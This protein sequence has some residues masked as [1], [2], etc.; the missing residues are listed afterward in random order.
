MLSLNVTIP[1]LLA[2]LREHALAGSC[3]IKGPVHAGAQ[4]P[5][6]ILVYLEWH[7]ETTPCL[8]NKFLLLRELL[9]CYSDCDYLILTLLFP[10][11]LPVTC[12]N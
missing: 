10:D 12:D 2:P 3:T 1:V 5:P 8:E 7:P 4:L 11:L 6:P 9:R